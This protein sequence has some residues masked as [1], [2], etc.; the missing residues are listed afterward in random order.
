LAGI[1]AGIIAI[2]TAV[3]PAWIGEVRQSDGRT[4]YKLLL[5]KKKHFGNLFFPRP[6]LKK[7]SNPFPII[8]VI[9]AIGLAFIISP[10][11]SKLHAGTD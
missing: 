7:M 8:M 1:A 4:M 10:V 11:L 5:R 2:C 3:W 6:D 9:V